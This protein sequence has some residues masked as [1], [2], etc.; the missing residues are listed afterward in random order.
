MAGKN[1]SLSRF[2]ITALLALTCL[3]MQDGFDILAIS[4]AANAIA[5][6]W[7]I[8]RARL[9]L[10]LSAGLF[11][12]MV[13]A[14]ALSPFADKIGRK[15]ITVLGLGL[16]GT[17]ML[18][19]TFAPSIEVL[20]IGRIIT[21]LGVGAILAS[22]NTLVAEFACERYRGQAV[23]IL[24]LG[25]PLGAFFSGFIV[26]WLLDVGS[27]RHVF[28]FGAATSFLFIP[29]V[30]T[31]PESM[32]YLAKSG[33]PD[34]LEKI[35]KT[36]TKL[37]LPTLNALP[38]HTDRS[39]PNALRAVGTLFNRD[40]RVR[41]ALIWMAFFLVLTTLY[42]LLS[43]IP[44]LLID[45]GFSEDQ[46]NRGGR[47][48]NLVGMGGILLIAIASRWVRPSAITSIYLVILFFLLLLLGTQTASYAASLA[49]IA[50][51]GFVIHGSMIGLYATTP[52]LYPADIRA[53]GMGWAIGLSRFGAVLGPASAGFLLEG[54]WSPQQ[55]FQAFSIPALLGAAIVFVLWRDEKQRARLD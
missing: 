26:S 22:I 38:A 37:N 39:S 47:L 2:Q 4:Y 34:A 49:V 5:V 11:G 15:P 40:Y 48:I 25:F 53:T 50:A 17:G 45:A 46:G 7:Q 28:A 1:D 24:Q 12:M 52:V 41:T 23:A 33:R 31:L 27:W 32:D 51:I 16:S 30:A 55:L 43:W 42:F 20:M 35:N 21:G 6:D 10:V 54:G 9:G 29:I 36:R 8:D 18:V 14:M 3:N 44:K 19:A 13:G